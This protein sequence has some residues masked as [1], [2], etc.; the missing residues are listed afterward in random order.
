MQREKKR[1]RRRSCGFF[2]KKS[3]KGKKIDASTFDLDK[4]GENAP[5]LLLI[6][7]VEHMEG[8]R[9]HSG[10]KGGDVL[11]TQTLLRGYTARPLP[12]VTLHVYP[13]HAFQLF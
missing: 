9:L 3:S 11:I 5:G 7:A 1:T 2:C 4:G 12:V 8:H 6:G 13:A 10:H